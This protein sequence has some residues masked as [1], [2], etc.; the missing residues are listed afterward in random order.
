M[1][2]CAVASGHQLFHQ[3]VV[4]ALQIDFVENFAHAADGPQLFDEGQV[5][6]SLCSTRLAGKSNFSSLLADLAA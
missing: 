3:L 1:M 6:S 2:P 4:L 5:S